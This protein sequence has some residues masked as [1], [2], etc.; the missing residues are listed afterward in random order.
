[1]RVELD[2]PDWVD[3]RHIRIMA[4]VELVAQK[5][6]QNDYWQ[7]KETR[8]NRCGKCC[9]GF[10]P[11]K[12]IYPVVNGRC[13]HLKERNGKFECAIALYQSRACENDPPHF[14]ERGE[15]SITYKE[16]PCK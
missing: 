2:L 3:E 11:G 12:H 16:V 6:A 8:C 14:I 9:M 1:M 4:G 15:C 10:K 13:I 7:V 5:L